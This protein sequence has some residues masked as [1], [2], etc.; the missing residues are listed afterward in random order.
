MGTGGTITG[1][2]RYLKKKNPKIKI[3]GVDPV[4]SVYLD[5]FKTGKIPKIFKT[6]KVEGVG[7]DFLPKTMDFSVVDDVIQVSDKDCFITARDLAHKEGILA[8]GSSGMVLFA[9]GKVAK[10]LQKGMLVVLLPDSG[11]NYLTKFYNEEWMRDFG[12]LEESKDSIK[13]LLAK[14]L[15][16][17][18]VS[19]ST[20]P[21][22]AIKIM[23]KY[24]IS[25]MPLID[26]KKVVGTI[27][28]KVLVQN[29]FGKPKIP[30]TVS[31]IMDKNFI[32]LAADA[33]IN[34]LAAVLSQK[35]MVIIV[36]KKGRP[37]DVLTRID[38]LKHIQS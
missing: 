14:K 11:K 38:L 27:C 10:K 3:I 16:L 33:S 22:E 9:A 37:I 36:D 30:V 2:G 15:H 32:T 24:Q 17:I 8:G 26:N 6:Y 31:D 1:I 25:Q 13:P 29:L 19:S 4:G 21:A 35:E 34:Q 20:T 12:F 7:E 5:Y 18:A 23:T 28:E